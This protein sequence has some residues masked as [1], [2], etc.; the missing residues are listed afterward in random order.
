MKILSRLLPK[1]VSGQLMLLVALSLIVA[2]AINLY[3][4]V[5][6]SRLRARSN[7]IE[8][9]IDNIVNH[10]QDLPDI[11]GRRLPYELR[12]RQFTGGRFYLSK[13]SSV[14]RLEQTRLLKGYDT[15]ITAMLNHQQ[16]EYQDFA[17]ALR[18]FKPK[19]LDL[20]LGENFEGEKHG[21]VQ[22]ARSDFDRYAFPRILN[23]YLKDDVLEL[24]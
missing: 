12:G 17:L 15:E 8:T 11:N 13:V 6:E 19:L 2:Q 23:D 7:I 5:G 18:P 9:V 3:I 10:V 16:L 20:E 24:F 14:S 22:V 4:L 1:N 21:W